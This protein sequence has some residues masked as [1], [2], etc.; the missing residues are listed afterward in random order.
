MVE[1]PLSVLAGDLVWNPVLVEDGL[2]RIQS[3]S[4]L[5]EKII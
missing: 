3:S 2:V 4:D 1:S 5:R